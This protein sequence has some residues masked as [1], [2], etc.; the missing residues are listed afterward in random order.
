[1]LMLNKIVCKAAA[2]L[3]SAF[4]GCWGLL[5]LNVTILSAVWDDI[6]VEYIVNLIN[7]Q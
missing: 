7:R 4:S 5:N 2:V 1:M 6:L 3:F